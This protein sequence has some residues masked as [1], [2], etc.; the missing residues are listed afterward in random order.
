[1]VTKVT[2]AARLLNRGF[3]VFLPMI[4]GTSLSASE[5]ADSSLRKDDPQPH[6]RYISPAVSWQQEYHSRIIP[7][8]V[9]TSN[10]IYTIPQ[11]FYSGYPRSFLEPVSRIPGMGNRH[12]TKSLKQTTF[13]AITNHRQRASQSTPSQVAPMFV[14]D[15]VGFPHIETGTR[16]QHTQYKPY[17]QLLKTITGADGQT[18]VVPN[19][20]CY[21]YSIGATARRAA[22]YHKL[23]KLYADRYGIDTALVK[24]VIT[25]ESCF[26]AGAKSHRGAY[27]LMQ[28]MP[29]TAS[30]LGVTNQKSVEQN[31]QAGIRYLG[32]LRKRF[33]SLELTLAAYNAGPGNVR[34]FDGIPPFAETQSY[35]KTVISYYNRYSASKQYAANTTLDS[36]V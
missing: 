15:S 10:K 23:I 36:N 32:Q 33:G 14:F 4:L 8:F 27:G 6:A 19:L 26:R 12:Y 13:Q 34:R 17:S 28:L 7:T 18:E 5:A 25:K 2:L 30:W 16:A 31:L 21:G 35:V 1:M 11:R 29:E 24:A 22:R 3:Y 20:R 9:V